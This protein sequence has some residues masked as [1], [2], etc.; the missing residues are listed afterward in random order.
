[1]ALEESFF[2]ETLL[3]SSI[4]RELSEEEL[5]EYRRPFLEAGE[6]RRP[7]LAGPR[8]LPIGGQPEDVAAIVGDYAAYLSKS[9]FPK[10][11]INAD[12]GATDV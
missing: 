12:P 3:P 9:E 2:V 4:L 5:A 6:C 1:M 10:L 7:T 8:Q 11:F